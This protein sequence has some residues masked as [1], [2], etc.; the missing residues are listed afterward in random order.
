MYPSYFTYKKNHSHVTSYVAYIV[1]KKKEKKMLLPSM[2]TYDQLGC[3]SHFKL[4]CIT[5][6]ITPVELQKMS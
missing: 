1:K 6:V 3:L 4:N 2:F 5:P